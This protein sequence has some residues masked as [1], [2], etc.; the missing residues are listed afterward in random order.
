MKIEKYVTNSLVHTVNRNADALCKVCECMEKLTKMAKK[1]KA[2]NF[3][4]YAMILVS[5]WDIAALK[6]GYNKMKKELDELKAET[7]S[8]VIDDFTTGD[9]EM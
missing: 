3:C 2:T 8:T 1:Q 9:K 5:A 6:V 7:D 4:L